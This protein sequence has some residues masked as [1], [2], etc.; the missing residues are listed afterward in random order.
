VRL[1]IKTTNPIPA[2]K[3]QK[4]TPKDPYA[5]VNVAKSKKELETTQFEKEE[6]KDESEITKPCNHKIRQ[7]NKKSFL[8]RK[9]ALARL[10]IITVCV[11]FNHLSQVSDQSNHP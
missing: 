3:R 6:E 9:R 5:P 7:N 8:H 1:K 2:P 10:A 11:L 4:I